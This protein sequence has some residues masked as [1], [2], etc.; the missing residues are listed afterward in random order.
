MTKWLEL[1]IGITLILFGTFVTH[2]SGPMPGAKPGHQA[3][4][5]FRIVLIAFGIIFALFS[6]AGFV[7][8]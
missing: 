7:S 2:V 1:I 6:L 4:L 3:P 8:P 5:R